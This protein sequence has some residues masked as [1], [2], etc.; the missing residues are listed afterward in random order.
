MIPVHTPQDLVKPGVDDRS[1]HRSSSINMQSS[2]DVIEKRE[3]R[4]VKCC[5]E[6]D[7]FDRQVNM[8]NH[9]LTHKYSG[10]C[11]KEKNYQ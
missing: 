10:Y 3:I 5:K 2:G 8:V 9:A 7:L 4:K 11:L 1:A 6:T